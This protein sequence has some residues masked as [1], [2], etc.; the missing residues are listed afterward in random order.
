MVHTRSGDER[1]SHAGSLQKESSST[2]ATSSTT[3]G[4]NSLIVG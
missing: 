1:R 3:A 4:T 2:A